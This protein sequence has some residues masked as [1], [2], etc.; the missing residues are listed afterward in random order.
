MKILDAHSWN[1]KNREKYPNGSSVNVVM[2]AYA[3]Y[4]HRAMMGVKLTEK[5]PNPNDN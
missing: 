1:I 4:Y 5:K 2:T 3:E